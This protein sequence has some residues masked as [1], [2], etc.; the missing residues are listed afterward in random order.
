MSAE[1]DA[2]S[3]ETVCFFRADP[4]E[5][6]THAPDLGSL[7]LRTW[8]PS[9]DGAPRGAF[10]TRTSFAWWAMQRAGAFAWDDLAIYAL[11][12]S[13]RMVHRLLVT[14]RWY[15]FGFMAGGDRQLGMLWTAEDCRGRGL[16][17]LGMMAAHAEYADRASSFWYLV[18]AD[19]RASIRL[20]EAMG[21]RLAGHG[22]RT[23]PMGLAP[24]GRFVISSP[25]GPA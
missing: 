9:R 17:K 5:L 14:P 20:A 12:E 4:D 18:D 13:G 2:G 19:N 21:Y 7:T 3:Q 22:K 6:L 8:R 16:A 24:F 10:A 23:S 15:R 1:N 25:R 11:F